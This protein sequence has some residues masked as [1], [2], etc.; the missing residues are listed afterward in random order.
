MVV[1]ILYTVKIK[2]SEKGFVFHYAAINVA[3]FNLQPI[4]KV[5]ICK[6][7]RPRKANRNTF[8]FL[9]STIKD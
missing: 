7:G 1:Y 9:I 6:I 5:L 2:E 3:S 8:C 4:K